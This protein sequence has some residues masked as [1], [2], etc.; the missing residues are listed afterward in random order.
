M[1]ELNW[2]A[3]WFLISNVESK[4]NKNKQNCKGGFC[5]N[6]YIEFFGEVQVSRQDRSINQ[7][8]DEK[9]PNF[10]CFSRLLYMF[11]L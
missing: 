5:V 7:S 10:V 3:G 11:I 9:L 2:V 6:I 8:F 1:W 4:K